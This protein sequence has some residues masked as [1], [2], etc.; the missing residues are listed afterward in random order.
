MISQEQENSVVF[1]GN[2]DARQG[3]LTIRTDE[4]TVYY[5]QDR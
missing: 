2:V 5:S 1:I 4:M 3:D